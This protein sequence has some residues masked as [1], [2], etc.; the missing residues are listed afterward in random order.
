[1]HIRD[2]AKNETRKGFYLTIFGTWAIVA[3]YAVFHDQYLVRICPEHF[4]E[5]HPNPLGIQNDQLLATYLAFLASVSPGLGLGM[6]IYAV[7]RL[8]ERPKIP[9]ALLLRKVVVLVVMTELF[10]L[11]SLFYVGVTRKGLYPSR[12]YPDDSLAMLST[13][14][15][16]LTTYLAAVLGSLFL[17]Y[18]FGVERR[19]HQPLPE[20][21]SSN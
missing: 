9:A 15:V 17:L 10:A 1:M 6:A 14:T 19:K 8:G 12:F 3:V 20:H 21:R 4:T 13:Q 7:A 18:H 11:S 5:Y 16:Q 2:L